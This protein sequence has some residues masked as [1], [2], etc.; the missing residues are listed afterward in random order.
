LIK[1]QLLTGYQIKADTLF[2]ALL[3]KRL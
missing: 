2:G 3:K 1:Q